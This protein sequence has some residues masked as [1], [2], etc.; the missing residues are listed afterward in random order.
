M[1][2]NTVVFLQAMQTM[3]KQSNA[4]WLAKLK[5][6]TQYDYPVTYNLFNQGNIIEHFGARISNSNWQRRW[7]YI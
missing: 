4:I 2:E 7:G 3:Y 6:D 1:G 5:G